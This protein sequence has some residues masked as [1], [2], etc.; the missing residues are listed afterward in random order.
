MQLNMTSDLTQSGVLVGSNHQYMS[1]FQAKNVF[2]QFEICVDLNFR[3][4]KEN[5]S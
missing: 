3:I 4:I 5:L 1:K 2:V